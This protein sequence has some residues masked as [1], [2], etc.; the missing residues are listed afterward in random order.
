[1]Y[2]GRNREQYPLFTRG[3]EGV[4]QCTGERE[5]INDILRARRPTSA[6]S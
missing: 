6:V 4:V 1:M 2:V 5:E 3:I